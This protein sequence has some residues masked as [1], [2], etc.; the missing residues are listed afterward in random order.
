MRINLSP[1]HL[2]NYNDY[3]EMCCSL[4]QSCSELFCFCVLFH[5]SGSQLDESCGLLVFSLGLC[6]LRFWGSRKASVPY[7]VS[8]VW[9]LLVERDLHFHGN[10]P[11]FPTSSSVRPTVLQQITFM[12][13]SLQQLP[14]TEPQIPADPPQAHKSQP[15]LLPCLLGCSMNF[16]FPHPP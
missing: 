10:S 2:C 6:V 11:A 8:Q 12:V 14:L 4:S 1:P 5:Y 7:P 9:D 3:H 13:P 16:A 15:F